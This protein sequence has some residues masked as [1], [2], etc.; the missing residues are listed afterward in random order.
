MAAGWA[1]AAGPAWVIP[2]SGPSNPGGLKGSCRGA[3]RGATRGAPVNCRA[4]A[5]DI[6]R[7]CGAARSEGRRVAPCTPQEQIDATNTK[8][9][10]IVYMGH[11]NK[12]VF[13]VLK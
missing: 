8:T 11:F 13:E 2:R 10:G 6:C 7:F 4:T 1:A 5:T 12:A 9:R 3:G